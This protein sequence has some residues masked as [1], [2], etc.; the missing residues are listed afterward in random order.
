M[1]QET[2][3]VI[4]HEMP[5]LCSLRK[6]LETV[7]RGGCVTADVASAYGSAERSRSILSFYHL[8]LQFARIS[9]LFELPGSTNDR[10]LRSLATKKTPPPHPRG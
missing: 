6:T 2:T 4:A 9:K 3:D 8:D 7:A 5:H 1:R 10:G